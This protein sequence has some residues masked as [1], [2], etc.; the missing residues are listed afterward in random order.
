MAGQAPDGVL[1]VEYAERCARIMERAKVERRT[2]ESWQDVFETGGYDGRLRRITGRDEPGVVAATPQPP[3]RRPADLDL[4]LATMPPAE[5]DMSLLVSP[6][7]ADCSVTMS[8]VAVGCRNLAVAFDSCPTTSFAIVHEADPDV[9]IDCP[10]DVSH[11]PSDGS[12]C[13]AAQDNNGNPDSP[14]SRQSQ[15]Q[16]LPGSSQVFR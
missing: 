16:A 10:L 8:P 1:S 13:N 5:A 3:P 9:T 4:S 11:R 12:P 2:G 15:S 14:G 7:T 6:I